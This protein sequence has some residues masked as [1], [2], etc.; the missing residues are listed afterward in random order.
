MAELQAKMEAQHK[1]KEEVLLCWVALGGL[2]WV[3]SFAT[4]RASPGT[5]TP[6]RPALTTSSRENQSCRVLSLPVR[7]FNNHRVIT[8]RICI[9]RAHPE[10]DAT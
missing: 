9:S 2:P 6:G 3:R 4:S 8:F 10:Q 1:E 5:L 7:W